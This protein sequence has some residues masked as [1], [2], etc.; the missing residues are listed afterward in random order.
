MPEPAENTPESKFNKAHIAARNTVERCNGVLKMRFRCLLKHRVLHYTPK[1][2]SKI[3]N[4]CTVLHNICILN[5]L[6]DPE[7]EDEDEHVDFGFFHENVADHNNIDAAER[8]ANPELLE[9]RKIRNAIIQ[10]YFT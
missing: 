7:P 9:G 4:A 5:K 6:P 8:R 2:A 1:T 3:I 10:N